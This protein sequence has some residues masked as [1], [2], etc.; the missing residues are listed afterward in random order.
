[1]KKILTLLINTLAAF[2]MLILYIIY[3]PFGVIRTLVDLDRF[4]DFVD[5][6]SGIISWIRLSWYKTTLKIRRMKHEGSSNN[7]H[8]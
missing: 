8:S 5:E 3:I 2:L 4:S 1:M 7:Q 6:F